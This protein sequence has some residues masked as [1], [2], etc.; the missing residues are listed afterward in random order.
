MC[1]FVNLGRLSSRPIPSRPILCQW[2]ANGEDSE[3]IE[4]WMD[5][6]D[7]NT[8]VSPRCFLL[9]ISTNFTSP[10][11][12]TALTALTSLSCK[13]L[14]ALH[15]TTRKTGQRLPSY[16]LL[17]RIL[18]AH[19]PNTD[20]G[21]L[22]IL[23][24]TS[25]STS[26]FTIFPL[27]FHVQH[28]SLQQSASAGYRHNQFLIYFGEAEELLLKCVSRSLPSLLHTLHCLL[29]LKLV[30]PPPIPSLVFPVRVF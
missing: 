6:D 27:S 10:T 29:L 12:F 28:Y 15:Q 17:I 19:R 16:L 24:S 30:L 11:A 5:R 8:P 9:S 4:W 20:P 13:T 23:I 7:I 21:G 1:G 18:S 25:T 22:S 26:T 14:H 3:W 2:V